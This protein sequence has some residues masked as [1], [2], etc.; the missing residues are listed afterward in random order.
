M[1]LVK[2]HVLS[3]VEAD[4]FLNVMKQWGYHGPVSSLLELESG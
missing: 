2:A 4:A 1:N 3:I